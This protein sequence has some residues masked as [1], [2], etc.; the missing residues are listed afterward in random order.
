MNNSISNI[1]AARLVQFIAV[2]VLLLIVV[3][4]TIMLNSA[5]VIA[6]NLH[7]EDTKRLVQN[8]ISRQ[9]EIVA[10]DQSQISNWDDTL[11][12]F[13]KEIDMGFVNREIAGW[14]WDD[15]DINTTI[16]V[17]PNSNPR[18][19][20]L[21]NKVAPLKKASLLLKQSSDL[22]QKAR[23]LYFS[24]RKRVN[25]GYIF[26]DNPVRQGSIAYA[27]DY[28]NIDGRVGIVLAQAIVP[29]EGFKL[30]EGNPH[31]L[32][33]FKHV[34]D[35]L[36]QTIG[37]RL[38]LKEFRFITQ[39]LDSSKQSTFVR[40]GKS[41]LL[42]VWNE[43]NPSTTIWSQSLPLL[44]I[45]ILLVGSAL[46]VVSHRYGKLLFE[47]QKNEE[48]NRFMAL[49]DALTGLPN[50]LQFNQIMSD[51]ATK[52]EPAN[53]AVLC[54]DL[55]RFKAVN[56]NHGHQV[57]DIVLATVAKRISK[58]IG[59]NG[60]VARMGG[61]EFIALLRD[62][63]E[64]ESIEEMCHDIVLSV[65]D[66]VIFEDEKTNVGASIGVAHWPRHA[67]TAKFVIQ[68]A[69]RALYQAKENGRGCVY[70]AED[71]FSSEFVLGSRAA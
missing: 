16:V 42:A 29:S 68:S 12:A 25:G 38:D 1:N 71:S 19:T 33:V 20:I 3:C 26:P 61:D 70:V 64:L 54:I 14:L 18:I 8:E 4:G 39:P 55:D 10:R 9:V 65:S 34:D 31:I 69:D 15:F 30:P 5:G 37:K 2:S 47:L 57:G 13:D 41:N 21:K 51:I 23:E 43:E 24:G 59:D 36:L 60:V 49:H 17:G 11:K 58:I 32:L 48:E 46:A 67:T 50:R 22:I 53:C 28:R 66:D 52:E 27:S 7:R 56:D 6:D 45:V 63:S 35:E 40:I 62:V 44:S